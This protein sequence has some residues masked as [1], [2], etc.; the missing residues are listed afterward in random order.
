MSLQTTQNFITFCRKLSFY[1]RHYYLCP[2][3]K[4]FKKVIL[5]RFEA[6]FGVINGAPDIA[7]CISWPLFKEW[8]V[9]G[10]KAMTS[11]CWEIS[12]S[13]TPLINTIQAR[14][15]RHTDNY[16][17]YLRTFSSYTQLVST[18]DK[19]NIDLS[20]FFNQSQPVGATRLIMRQTGF[21]I[22][23]RLPWLWFTLFSF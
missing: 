17:Q 10:V 5:W 21:S 2:E 22:P 12:G 3:R 13:P 6:P 14:L 8:C 1:Y 20:R 11:S 7:L 23:I 4:E 15:S 9:G 16:C 19:R 18:F